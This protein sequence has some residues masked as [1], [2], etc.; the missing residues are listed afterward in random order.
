MDAL[1]LLEQI[2]DIINSANRSFAGSTIKI[3]SLEMQGLVEDLRQTLIEEVR[4]ARKIVQDKDNILSEAQQE[5]SSIME[6]VEENISTLIDENK[7][8]EEAKKEAERVLAEAGERA[9][10]I[11]SGAKDYADGVLANLQGHLKQTLE[12]VERGRNQLQD[13][14]EYDE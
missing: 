7:I 10:K 14:T 13:R 8:V 3:N 2:E 4:Q 5:A 1:A 9:D 6:E 12:T 11:S